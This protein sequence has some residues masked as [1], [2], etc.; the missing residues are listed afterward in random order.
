M[1]GSCSPVARKRQRLG[2]EMTKAALCVVTETKR[3][4][5]GDISERHL[6]SRIESPDKAWEALPL[7]SFGSLLLFYPTVLWLFITNGAAE[8]YECPQAPHHTFI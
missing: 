1:L 4:T 3:H 5:P 2:R 6:S 7:L 8:L